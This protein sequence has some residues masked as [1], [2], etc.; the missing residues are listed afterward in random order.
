MDDLFL[1]KGCNNVFTILI[2]V[3]LKIIPFMCFVRPKLDTVLAT[4]SVVR[5]IPFPV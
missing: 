2:S 4:T 1:T 3:T 5:F